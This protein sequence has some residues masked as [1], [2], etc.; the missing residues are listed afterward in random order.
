MSSDPLPP[1]GE[2][3][4]DSPEIHPEDSAEEEVLQE[5][6]P[7]ME[8]GEEAPHRE[9]TSDLPKATVPIELPAAPAAP[10]QPAEQPEGDAA[11]EPASEAAASA[12]AEQPA[13]A[14]EEKPKAEEK[15]QGLGNWIRSLSMVEKLCCLFMVVGVIIFGLTVFAPALFDFPD[16]PEILVS[17]DFPLKGEHVEV[18]LADS[19]W[20]EPVLEG[21]DAD[22]VQADIAF[23]AVLEMKLKGSGG[24]RVLFRNADGEVVGDPVTHEVKGEGGFS[25]V[26]T[27]GLKDVGALA[28]YQSG[29]G[30]SWVAEFYEAASGASSADDYALL[31]KMNVSSVLK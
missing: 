15:P 21:P 16:E 28:G 25:A 2:P 5:G 6:L 1:S 3:K 20:R 23:V 7:P 12:Q 18:T 11:Q 9:D 4:P 27:S 26:C 30:G 10:G 29:Q 19:Y 13:P 31:F 22:T 8:E 14:A 17:K 24:I